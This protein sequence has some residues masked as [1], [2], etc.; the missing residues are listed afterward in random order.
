MSELLP[1][2]HPGLGNIRTITGVDSI[3]S[4]NYWKFTKFF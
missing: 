2:K 4:I 3:I 1:P